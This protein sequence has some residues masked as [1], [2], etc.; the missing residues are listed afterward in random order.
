MLADLYQ[1]DG[2]GAVTV[3]KEVSV[4]NQGW[5]KLVVT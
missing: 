5:R 4:I 3:A 1:P 2:G